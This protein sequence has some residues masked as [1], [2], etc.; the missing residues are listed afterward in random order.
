LTEA[1]DA[2]TEGYPDGYGINCAHPEH[3]AHRLS[4]DAE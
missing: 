3:F 4:A 2:A 1:V